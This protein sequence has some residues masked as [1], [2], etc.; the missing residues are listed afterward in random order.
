MRKKMPRLMRPRTATPP[1]TPPTIGPTA[2]ELR[3]E[4]GSG[5]GVVEVVGVV[6]T[7]FE[8]VALGGA[9]DVVV[10]VV[11]PVEVLVIVR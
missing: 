8:V 9:E 11:G 4:P 10:V 2:V 1:T 5:T 6:V 7:A 3:R